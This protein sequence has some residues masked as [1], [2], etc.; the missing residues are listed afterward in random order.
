KRKPAK[1]KASG[2]KRKSGL[3]QT[4]YTLSDDLAAIVGTKKSTR[5]QVVKKLWVYIKAH[6]CQ[7]A[8]NRRMINPDK[9][10]AAV[11]GNRPVDM[12]K[13]AGLISKHIK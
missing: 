9:K 10:L 13:M 7:D 2:G 5:P 12:L 6:K 1:K 8:K 11:L 3:T 4:Q